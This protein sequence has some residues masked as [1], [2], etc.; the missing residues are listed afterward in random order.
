MPSTTQKIDFGERVLI[1]FFVF[2]AAAS[3]QRRQ[4]MNKTKRMAWGAYTKYLR[5]NA[6]VK[7]FLEFLQ[8]THEM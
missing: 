1:D 4:A 3:F 8:E 2:R 5:S 7:I 6:L